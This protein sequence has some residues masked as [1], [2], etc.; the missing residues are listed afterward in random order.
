MTFSDG[1]TGTIRVGDVVDLKDD[2]TYRVLKIFAPAGPIVFKRVDGSH[3]RSFLRTPDH[4]VIRAPLLYNKSTQTSPYQH[5]KSQSTQTDPPPSASD[6]PL[7]QDILQCCGPDAVTAYHQG[8]PYCLGD[9][10]WPKRP[11]ILKR[12]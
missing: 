10:H 4:V 8:H 11:K 5:V 3:N 2:H 12:D 1:R 7:V 6:D 9:V